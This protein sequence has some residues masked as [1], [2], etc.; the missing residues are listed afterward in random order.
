MKES[1]PESITEPE[2]IA[3][4]ITM[5]GSLDD[6]IKSLL[7]FLGKSSTIKDNIKDIND[8]IKNGIED[9][10]VSI[11]DIPNI[12]NIPNIVG[13]LPDLIEDIKDKPIISIDPSE[14]IKVGLP[15]SIPNNI[16]VFSDNDDT[17]ES[18]TDSEDD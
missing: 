13:Y 17:T 2:T 3:S 15:R 10:S 5:E 14:P 7:N 16:E 12:G 6:K 8:T 1:N 18:E 4:V 9:L 11:K